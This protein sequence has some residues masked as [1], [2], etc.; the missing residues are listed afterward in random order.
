[1]LM[2]RAFT[3]AL[4]SLLVLLGVSLGNPAVRPSGHA[5]LSHVHDGTT[6][7]RHAVM[8]A[9]GRAAMAA[10]RPAAKKTGAKG[11]DG[12]LAVAG[13][14]FTAPF[15]PAGAPACCKASPP[16]EPAPHGYL[17]RAPPARA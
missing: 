13:I 1:M 15:I 8:V 6:P 11:A 7:L 10:L 2:S 14:A 12:A 17:A 9:T 4:L 5:P 16:S 3:A